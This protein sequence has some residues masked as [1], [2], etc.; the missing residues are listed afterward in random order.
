MGPRTVPRA[1]THPAV[2][3]FNRAARAYERGRPEYPTAAIRYIARQLHLGPTSTIVELGSGTGKL[4]RLLRTTTAAIVPIEPT[5]GMRAEFAR[6]IPDLPVLDGVAEAIPLPPHIADAVVA[7]QA[8][9]W[10]RPRPAFREIARVLR[11]G[12]GVALIW[13]R[14][15]E[16]VPWVHAAGHLIDPFFRT[17]PRSRGGRWRRV[18]ERGDLPFGPV[19]ERSFRHVQLLTPATAVDRFVSVSAI[20]VLPARER[21]RIARELRGILAR[22]P[23]TR[24]RARIELP[25]RADVYLT[26]RLRST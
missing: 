15:D 11:P 4:T 3:G 23:Q 5:P 26:R 14:R 21:A 10:F 16:S 7:A 8:F 9:H 17:V 25:Y 22:D 2:R 20:A 6:Q 12:G 1:R 24:G 19:V 13:N 18:L